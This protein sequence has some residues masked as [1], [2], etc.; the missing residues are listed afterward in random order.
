M[1]DQPTTTFPP[2]QI[3]PEQAAAAPN[4]G[5]RPKNCKRCNKPK[6]PKGV[7]RGTEG[8]CKC[9][10]PTVMTSETIEKLEAAFRNGFS[11]RLACIY[12][13]ISPDALYKYC[14]VNP[15][16]G[17]RKEEL[18]ST[19]DMRALETLAKDTETTG[20]ARYWAEKRV[21]DFM[22]TSKV[23][24]EDADAVLDD[25]PISEDEQNAL[26]LLRKARRR[27]IEKKSDELT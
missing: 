4:K 27:R 2:E 16:F 5:G 13:G 10:A 9:G 19:P 21:K 23:I 25:G 20:G 6:R 14:R 22:P 26:A 18:K 17:Q 1:T 7:Q 11:D 15:K 12:A 24:V 3:A 8:Y